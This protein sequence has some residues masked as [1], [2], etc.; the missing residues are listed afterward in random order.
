[1]DFQGSFGSD[2]YF[3]GDLDQSIIFSW[4]Q[5]P[6][7]NKWDSNNTATP[8]RN[9]WDSQFRVPPK[10][11]NHSRATRIHLLIFYW[12][13]CLKQK[14]TVIL[15]LNKV[16]SCSKHFHIQSNQQWPTGSDQ[17]QCSILI[18]PSHTTSYPPARPVG[19]ISYIPDLTIS[20]L[21]P[22]S[23]PH[24]YHL[25]A[26]YCSSLLSP[27]PPHSSLSSLHMATRW[28]F[29]KCRSDHITLLLEILSYLAITFI[30]AIIISLIYWAFTI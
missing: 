22:L 5:F 14:Q 20:P 4:T 6:L 24:H 27:L 16:I 15:V 7:G 26:R 30:I 1:M 13:D 12:T 28:H 23:C 9:E 29:L 2:T 21:L 3:L 10:H 25:S 17:K 19:Y 11:Q 8:S 18:F